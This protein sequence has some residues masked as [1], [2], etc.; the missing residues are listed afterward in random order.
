MFRVLSALALVLTTL[1]RAAC[2]EGVTSAAIDQLLETA[3]RSYG[4]FDTDG[5]FMASDRARLLIPCVSAVL[6]TRLAARYH[7]VEGL[8]R[9]TANDKQGSE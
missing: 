8:R 7:R 6:P 4:E 3:E 2:P 1:A 5:F 9:F